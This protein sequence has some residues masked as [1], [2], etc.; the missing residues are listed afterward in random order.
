MVAVSVKLVATGSL[1]WVTPAVVLGYGLY[2]GVRR[3]FALEGPEMFGAEVV[4]M[5]PVTVAFVVLLRGAPDRSGYLLV[6]LISV[7]GAIAMTAYV[8]S[9]GLLSLPMFGLLSY[10]EPV[11][12]FV[13]SLL[14]G[15]R[16][17]ASDGIAYGLLAVAL[18]VLAVAGFRAAGR[19]ERTV[20]LP[21]DET[22]SAARRPATPAD[23]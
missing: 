2:F 5:L 13:S 1:S 9:A 17:T 12:L 8:T 15:E 22:G 18:G 6:M 3:R 23:P 16:L 19:S 10:A 11:G 21:D 7:L 20:P 4:L 14:L